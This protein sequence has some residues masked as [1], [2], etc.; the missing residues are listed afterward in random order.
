M[1][2]YRRRFCQSAVVAGVASAFP[3]RILLAQGAQ[4]TRAIPSEIPAVTLSRGETTLEGA[5]VR[6]LGESLQGSLLLEGDFGFDGARRVWNGM[7]DQHPALIVRAANASDVANAITFARERELLTSVKGGGHSWAGRSVANGAL[8]I[9]L[10]ALSDVTVD[11]ARRRARAGGGALLFSLDYASLRHG[12]VT[13]AGVVS[14]TG[15]GGYTLGGGY[16]RLNRKMGLTIDNLVSAEL[17]TADGQVRRV[18]SNQNADLFWAI[19]GGGGNFGVVTEFEYALHEMNPAVLGGDIVWPWDQGRDILEFYAQYSTGL[20]DEMYVAPGMGVG[21][22]GA[23]VVSMDVCYCGDPAAGEQE[24]APLREFGNPIADGIGV[25][26][27]LTLQTRLDGVFRPGIRSYVKGGMV[28]E[29]TQGLIDSMIESYDPSR[30]VG[31]GFHTAGAAVARVAQ[32]DTAWP[33]RDSETMISAITA[34]DNPTDD[35]AFISANRDQWAALE[36]HTAGY[37][38][39]IQSQI[40]GVAANYGPGYDRLVAL[41]TAYDPTNLFRLNSNIQPA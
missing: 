4:S 13:T 34:W 36:P 7:H 14:H 35:D 3:G 25:V 18:S 27:Y 32:D 19:R 26:P 37:Y 12:L 11:V 38:A 29:F 24:L 28:R 22:N 2:I 21:P 33:Y 20:S 40:T 39:N 9:D 17:V 23:A 41:K 10:G 30:G 6:E 15:V 1:N 8:T 31:V 5:A 16:G